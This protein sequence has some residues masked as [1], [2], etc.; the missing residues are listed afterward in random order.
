L[1]EIANSKCASD[2]TSSNSCVV[3]L[4]KSRITV[5]ARSHDPWMLVEL[6]GDLGFEGQP[7]AFEDD[8][9]TEFVSHG[10]EYT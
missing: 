3:N 1:A 9:W 5:L 7:C 6:K 4:A 8:F 10:S 2:L